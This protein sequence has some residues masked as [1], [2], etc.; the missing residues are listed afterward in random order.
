MSNLPDIYYV[1]WRARVD[2]AAGCSMLGWC[3][4]LASHFSKRVPGTGDEFLVNAFGLAFDEITASSLVRVGLGRTLATPTPHGINPAALTIRSDPRGTPRSRESHLHTDDGT[5]VL[6]WQPPLLP[7]TQTAMLI[8]GDLA[9]H[10]FEGVA[11][12]L[13]S[14]RG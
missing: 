2:L 5:A 3:D 9:H 4:L 10:P 11:L 6:R 13:A 8:K 7:V 1:E 14:A 12:D